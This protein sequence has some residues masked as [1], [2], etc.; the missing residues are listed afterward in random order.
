MSKLNKQTNKQTTKAEAEE[1]SHG[2]KQPN[3]HYPDVATKLT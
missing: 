3:Y 1:M 2:P